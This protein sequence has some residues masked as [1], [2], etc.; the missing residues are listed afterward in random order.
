MAQ[1]I[2]I[3]PGAFV[4]FSWENIVQQWGQQIH[5]KTPECGK[6]VQMPHP[7][8]EANGTCPSKEA[9]NSTKCV[10]GR[11]SINFTCESEK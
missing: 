8:K 10:S 3:P 11:N 2:P 1:S 5:T 9:K 7:G 4:S 6:G